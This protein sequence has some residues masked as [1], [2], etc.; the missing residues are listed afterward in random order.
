MAI[1]GP[2]DERTERFSDAEFDALPRGSSGRIID[3]PDAYAW[4]TDA[5]REQMHGD[6]W[7]YMIDLDE[8]ISCMMAEFA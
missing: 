8:E 4:I 2:H 3:L 6:D 5:Q 1:K 7:S